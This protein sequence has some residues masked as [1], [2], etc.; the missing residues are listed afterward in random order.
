MEGELEAV[1]IYDDVLVGGKGFMTTRGQ[2]NSVE[3]FEGVSLIFDGSGSTGGDDTSL[4]VQ[5]HPI[6]FSA[7]DRLDQIDHRVRRDASH[8]SAISTRLPVVTTDNPHPGP[9]LCS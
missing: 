5:S 1:G 6:R 7:T 4:H 9:I 2:S 3:P 8:P